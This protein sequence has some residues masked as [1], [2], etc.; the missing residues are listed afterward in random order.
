MN[1]RL[2]KSST[3]ANLNIDTEFLGDSIITITQNYASISDFEHFLEL[4][5]HNVIPVNMEDDA[6]ELWVNKELVGYCIFD[7]EI[8]TLDT[9]IKSLDFDDDDEYNSFI[10]DNKKT[11]FL[12]SNL[13]IVYIVE[14]YQGIGLGVFFAQTINEIFNSNILAYLN[15]SKKNEFNKI[16]INAHAEY[17]S[18][19]GEMVHRIIH[20]DCKNFLKHIL[21]QE[22]SVDVQ[23]EYDACY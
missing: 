4:K 10:K 21:K 15:F 19:G 8:E 12:D 6:Y 3:A 20:G 1:K 18:E 9:H 23:F 11:L 2:I 14:K 13:K 7:S 16:E 17:E 22:L 5:E